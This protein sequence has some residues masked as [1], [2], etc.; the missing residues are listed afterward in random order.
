MNSTPFLELSQLAGYLL[1][2]DEEVPAAGV[3]TG[4]GQVQG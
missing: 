1:Y 2:G 3:I 4:I